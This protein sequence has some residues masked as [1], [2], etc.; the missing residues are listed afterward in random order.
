MTTLRVNPFVRI[1]PPTSIEDPRWSVENYDSKRCFSV[2]EEVAHLLVKISEATKSDGQGDQYVEAINTLQ[3]FD[4]L[5]DQ[6]RFEALQETYLLCNPVMDRLPIKWQASLE[7]H[8]ATKD[9]PFLNYGKDSNGPVEAL[10]RMS[11]Y[12]KR[13]PDAAR[14]K[15]FHSDLVREKIV[16]PQNGVNLLNTQA[17]TLSFREKLSAILA[18][19]F[20]VTGEA[21]CRWSEVPL[22][23]RTSPSGGSRH[24]C[25]GYVVFFERPSQSASS[26]HIQ[27]DLPA[28]V[29]LEEHLPPSW[30]GRAFSHGDFVTS[31]PPV[32][33][34]LVIV[35]CLFE[36]NMYR[37]RESRTFRS[38]HMDGGHLLRT[39]ETLCFEHGLLTTPVTNET[40]KDWGACMKLNPLTE[41]VLGA[42]EVCC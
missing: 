13:E 15:T 41:G 36:R 18:V 40:L 35:T 12:S 24:P 6:V 38:V 5:I 8:L 30:I 19:T 32:E 1:S 7:Y 37:Y 31:P 27:A 20:G 16:S 10:D 17:Q 34:A 33:R 2:S 25:E 14:I 4:I 22:V 26:F 28:L 29:K 21:P 23:R 11:D 3:E 42:V 9:F 39:L